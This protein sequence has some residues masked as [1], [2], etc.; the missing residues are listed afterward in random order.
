MS[1]VTDLMFVLTD[2]VKVACCGCGGVIVCNFAYCDKSLAN[3]IGFCKQSCIQYAVKFVN[4]VPITCNHPKIGIIN[5]E[6]PLATALP[7]PNCPSSHCC[8]NV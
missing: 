8:A 7:C 5:P 6:F 3:Q 2:L 4:A 1:L